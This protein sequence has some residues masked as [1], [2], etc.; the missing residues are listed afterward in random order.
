MW[1]DG[2]SYR[3]TAALFDIRNKGCLSDWERRYET[4]GIDALT[5]RRKGGPRSMSEP[6]IPREPQALQSDEAKSREEL[7]SELNYL[8]MTVILS[9]CCGESMCFAASPRA[10]GVVRA[11]QADALS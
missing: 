6:P 1:K 9:R 2:L 8:R 4:G 3:Q 10:A 5:S 7:L 11:R